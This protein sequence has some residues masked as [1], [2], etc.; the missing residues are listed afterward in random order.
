MRKLAF[1]LVLLLLMISSTVYAQDGA[2]VQSATTDTV[3]ITWP[4]PVSEVWGSGD[5]LGTASVPNMAYYY[6]E[7]IT[8]NDDLTIPQNAP[9]LPATIASTTPV[10]DGSLATLDTT[11]VPD[12]LYALRL[13]VTTQ[14]GQVFY[15]VVSPIR[16]NNTRFRAV[17]ASMGQA[18]TPVPTPTTAPQDTTARVVPNEQFTSVNM[19]RCDLVDNDRCP[20]I[21]TL[22]AG[23]SG[24][25]KAL[26]SN[27]TGWFQVQ[28]PSGT[29][30]WVSPTVVTTSGDLSG[31]GRAQPPAP[32][33][34]V[35]LPVGQVSGVI[36]NGVAIQGGAATCNQTFNVQINVVNTG[37]TVAPAGTVTLQDVNVSTGQ[38]TFTGY[39]NYPSL[40]PGANFVAVIPAQTSV[41]YN[42]AHELRASTNG[43]Q[44]NTRYQLNQGNCGQASTPQQPQSTQRTFAP[45]E[46]TIQFSGTGE[47]YDRP[48]G[49]LVFLLDP[50]TYP[51]VQII[52]AGGV[53]WFEISFAD[54]TS[55][56]PGINIGKLGNCG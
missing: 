22:R 41:F 33:A 52:R 38:V 20:V 23:E 5:V 21:A 45:G 26:S 19:R 6:I 27:N 56:T 35:Q 39:G 25:V 28:L 1:L 44:S 55:W 2:S 8:L 13:T 42:E 30:G 16:V 17:M 36:P 46:C 9:W 43:R 37:T 7:Y 24:L 4:P 50:G 49:S 51:A 3:V 54:E 29:V 53:D 31:V 11:T 47:A 10:V 32:L 15:D 14:D 18:Q 48:E 40:N 12:G 34:V